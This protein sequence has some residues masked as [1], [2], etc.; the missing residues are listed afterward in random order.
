MIKEPVTWPA[1]GAIMRWAC[2]LALVFLVIGCADSTE[3]EGG[4]TVAAR[5]L[6]S[7]DPSEETF[8]LERIEVS[9]P[10]GVPV[11]VELVGSN[12]EVDVEYGFVRVDVALRN[13]GRAPLYPPAR[14]WVSEFTPNTVWVTNAN[15]PNLEPSLRWG[16]DYCELLGDD[17]LLGP[18]E[19]SE[20]WRWHFR[21]PDLVS[22]SF[23]ADVTMDVDPAPAVI[24][25][26]VFEDL[27]QNGIRERNEGPW[28]YAMVIL[29]RPD[30]TEEAAHCEDN[31]AFRFPVYEPGLYRLRL[32]SLVD[33]IVCFTTANPLEVMLVPDPD[34]R[35]ES[36][37]M[38]V[39]GAICA[40]CDG[41]D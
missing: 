11:P 17:D 12:V 22:F 7:F 39:F 21:N 19:T 4:D 8:V 6:G 38:A 26:G 1:K 16:F 35:P 14:V 20:A 23:R 31:G 37:G 5:F 30:G 27:N 33:C 25:G 10:G 41:S 28:P 29:T 24:S 2:A 18:G 9:A 32:E 40:P 36:F 15:I 34:G 13:A 3:P